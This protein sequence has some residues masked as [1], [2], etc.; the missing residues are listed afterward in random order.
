MDLMSK[1][2]VPLDKLVE[3]DNLLNSWWTVGADNSPCTPLQAAAGS[4]PAN[5]CTVA[6]GSSMMMASAEMEAVQELAWTQVG[7]HASRCNWGGF[8][9]DHQTWR[10]A[11]TPVER[12][13]HCLL[14]WTLP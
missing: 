7:E 4:F 5:F 3:D 14:T 11:A 8:C 12:E 1:H 9:R 6:A 10:R 2:G 13:V